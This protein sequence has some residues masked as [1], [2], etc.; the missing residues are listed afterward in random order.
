MDELV[1]SE[2]STKSIKIEMNHMKAVIYRGLGQVD[3]GDLDTPKPRHGELVVKMMASGVCH[4]DI[5]V[6]HGRYGNSTFPLV[7][8]HEYAG[9]IVEV[10]A[11]V[12]QFKVGDRVVVDPNLHCGACRACQKGLYNLCDQLG[13]YGVTLNGGFAEY[14]LVKAS[15]LMPI[16]Q[17][18]FELAALA[19]P[20][21]CVLTGINAALK[22]KMSNALIFGA[23]PI[24]ILMALALK[25]KG[26]ADITMVDKQTSR[27][28]LVASFGFHAV[29]V[30][31]DELQ[32]Q[33]QQFDFTADATG[34]PVVVQDLIEYTANGGSALI[35][36]VCAPDAKISVAPFEIFRRQLSLVGTHSLNHNIVEA[37]E[38]I[39][40]IGPMLNNIISHKVALQDVPDFLNHNAGKDSLKV[41]AVC[42]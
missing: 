39:E 2:L 15:N 42:A 14:S 29:D 26:I 4:T 21:G 31:S 9:Q 34:I 27:L 5:D 3:F 38:T 33:A 30:S 25:T 22:P 17:L 28:E 7:P 36:G 35:F 23:G 6:L 24:G 20:I 16:G 41:Q 8:G 13:A 11:D 1:P 32:S 40:K 18:S 12:G 10:G 37:I 19:E